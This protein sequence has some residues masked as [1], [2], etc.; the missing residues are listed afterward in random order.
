MCLNG[1]KV[2]QLRWQAQLPVLFSIPHIP[3]SPHVLYIR[4]LSHRRAQTPTAHLAARHHVHLAH[5]HYIH[6][7]ISHR[8]PARLSHRAREQG[9]HDQRA[10]DGQVQG[11]GLFHAR[12]LRQLLLLVLLVPNTQV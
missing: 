10:R 8:W 5:G 12:V 11:H 2:E 4:V 7:H 6:I 3:V 1:L 9:S